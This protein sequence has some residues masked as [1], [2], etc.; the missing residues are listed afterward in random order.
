M[1][2]KILFT[3]LYSRNYYKSTIIFKKEKKGYYTMY[4]FL[5]G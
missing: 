2:Y 3:M 4:L 1:K 5:K